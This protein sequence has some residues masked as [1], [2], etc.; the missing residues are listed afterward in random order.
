MQTE[1]KSEGIGSITK[2]EQQ[3]MNE[4]EDNNPEQVMQERSKMS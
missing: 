3:V 4:G 2:T 1:H